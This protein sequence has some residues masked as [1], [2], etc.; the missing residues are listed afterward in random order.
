[1]NQL[2]I[3][4]HPRHHDPKLISDLL[5]LRLMKAFNMTGIS[6][7]ISVDTSVEFSVIANIFIV[8]TIGNGEFAAVNTIFVGSTRSVT[9]KR[10][11]PT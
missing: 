8:I 4:G 10:I 5:Q 1:M 9:S 6:T 3:N 2:T 11:S 7:S